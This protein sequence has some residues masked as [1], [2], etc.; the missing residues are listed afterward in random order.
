CEMGASAD[1]L[2]IVD[3]IL[4]GLARGENDPWALQYRA[5]AMFYFRFHELEPW[6]PGKIPSWL[7]DDF[8][9]W[10]LRQPFGFGEIGETERY[11]RRLLD[12][13]ERVRSQLRAIPQDA[14]WRRLAEPMTL[15]PNFIATYFSS[16]DLLPLMRARSDIIE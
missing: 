4:S 15:L 14:V 3:E 12:W 8:L 10:T 13:F 6:D 11:Y 2:L 5:A 7:W 9:A 16:A 1:E